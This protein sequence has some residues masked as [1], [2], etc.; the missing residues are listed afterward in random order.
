MTTKAQRTSLRAPGMKLRKEAHRP[1]R[2]SKGIGAT[3]RTLTHAEKVTCARGCSSTEGNRNNE[4]RAGRWTYHEG[5][6]G[7]PA[8]WRKANSSKATAEGPRQLLGE[9]T[10][11]NTGISE[12]TRDA[13]T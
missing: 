7:T 10:G 11:A 6:S 9:A 1:R 3:L 13:D 4:G 8:R 2:P 5:L 12:L